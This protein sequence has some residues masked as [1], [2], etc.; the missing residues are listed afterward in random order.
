MVENNVLLT[1]TMPLHLLQTKKFVKSAV[2]T[3]IE[4]MNYRIYPPVR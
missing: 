1:D 4:N 3:T 2:I